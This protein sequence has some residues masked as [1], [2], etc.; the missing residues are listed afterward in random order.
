MLYARALLLRNCGRFTHISSDFGSQYHTHV[1]VTSEALYASL[2]REITWRHESRFIDLDADVGKSARDDYFAC[3]YNVGAK[4]LWFTAGLFV[5]EN[6]RVV[7]KRAM[8]RGQQASG[9]RPVVDTTNFNVVDEDYPSTGGKR[10]DGSQRRFF[11]PTYGRIEAV[12]PDHRLF[13]FALA[14]EIDQL[15]WFK[16]GQTF[17]MGKKRTMFQ[18]TAASSVTQLIKT[19]ESATLEEYQPIQ[20]KLDEVKN[21]REYEV[22]AGTARYLLVR[23]VSTEPSLAA[24]FVDSREIGPI[25]RLLPT[26][27]VERARQIISG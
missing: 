20:I 12:L 14:A 4:P 6:L 5:D 13:T 25:R 24:S 8:S 16:S 18:L 10:L 26:F 15:E 7:P 2:T 21:F 3:D 17:L 1:F 27:W 23:G 9:E 19:N 22:I 11:C